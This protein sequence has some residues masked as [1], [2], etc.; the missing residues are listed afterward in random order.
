M[1]L[2]L[3]REFAS[4]HLPLR[5][6]SVQTSQLEILACLLEEALTL[7]HEDDERS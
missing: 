7:T 3:E 1:R 5:V 2:L 6:Q 4:A